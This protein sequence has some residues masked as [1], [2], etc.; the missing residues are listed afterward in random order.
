M[1][2]LGL[3]IQF[4]QPSMNLRILKILRSENRGLKGLENRDAIIKKSSIMV[5][6]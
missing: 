6:Y 4:E 2:N 1:R 5:R 3:F